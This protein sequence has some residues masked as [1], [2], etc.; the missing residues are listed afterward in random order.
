MSSMSDLGNH[1]T[2]S[3]LVGRTNL[4]R[5]QLSKHPGIGQRGIC[6][7]GNNRVV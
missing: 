7:L 3:L 1:M 6:R 4:L 5:R 2:G